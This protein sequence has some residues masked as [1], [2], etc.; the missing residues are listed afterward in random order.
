[1]LKWLT[2]TN[3]LAYNEQYGIHYG[4]K[5]F[6]DTGQGPYSL[7]GGHDIQHNDTQHNDTQ[8]NRLYCDTQ[9]NDTE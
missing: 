9:H 8:L 3:A 7:K 5:K 1:M 6:Y 4:R 2:V